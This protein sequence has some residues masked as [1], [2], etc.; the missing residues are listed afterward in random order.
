MAGRPWPQSP[1]IS[2]LTSPPET[3]TSCHPEYA[4]PNSN[5]I[6]DG[7]TGLPSIYTLLL[8]AQQGGLMAY[9]ADNIDLFRRAAGYVDKLLKGAKPVNLP[10]EFPTNFELI[11]NLKLLRK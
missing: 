1:S 7:T 3:I 2:Q 5:H 10:V 8:F 9:S 11:V 6:P 4:I